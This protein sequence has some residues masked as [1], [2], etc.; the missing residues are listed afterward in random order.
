MMLAHSFYFCSI[1]GAFYV[2]LLIDSFLRTES[3]GIGTENNSVLGD[4]TVLFILTLPFLVIFMIGCHSMYLCNLV[5]DELKA[6]K[7]EREGMQE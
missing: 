3:H 7:L 6:R 5:M 1:I 2:F 4:R